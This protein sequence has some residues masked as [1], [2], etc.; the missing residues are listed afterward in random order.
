MRIAID[1][2]VLLS[3]II[4]ANDW[5]NKLM[6][7]IIEKHRL[8]L[9]SFVIEELNDVV[10]RKFAGKQEAV[11]RFL[12]K[13]PFEM[14]YTPHEMKRDVFQIRDEKDYPVLYTAI[15]GDV[16]IFITGDKDFLDVDIEKPIILTP[17]QFLKKYC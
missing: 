2:N 7:A 8:V 9:P 12:S 13:L 4:F 15:I 10:E 16:D 1:T 14:L 11:E 17:V 6:R 3:A 5:T